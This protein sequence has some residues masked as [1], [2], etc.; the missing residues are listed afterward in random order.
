VEV[1]IV[2]PALLAVA[3]IRAVAAAI[4]YIAWFYGKTGSEGP[5]DCNIKKPAKN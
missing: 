5:G 1:L 3:A 2:A 4:D